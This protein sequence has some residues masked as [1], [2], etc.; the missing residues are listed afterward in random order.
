M[1][2]SA[3]RYIMGV[4]INPITSKGE[5]FMKQHFKN[6]MISAAVVFAM[7]VGMTGVS[8]HAAQRENKDSN[9]FAGLSRYSEENDRSDVIPLKIED[10]TLYEYAADD[11]AWTVIELDGRA[12]QVFS[13]ENLCVLME[14]G[15]LFYDGLT[16]V[17]PDGENVP[18][19]SSYGM[20]IAGKV[21]EQNEAEPFLDVNFNLQYLYFRALLAS[22]ELLCEDMEG[23][24]RVSLPGEKPAALAGNFILTE[25]GNV[26]YLNGDAKKLYDGGDIVAV[27][28]CETAARGVGLKANG[29]AV[30][31]WLDVEAPDLSEWKNLAAVR[32]GFYFTVG[33]DLDGGVHYADS[34]A[35]AMESVSEVLR[36]WPDVTDLAICYE[37]IV[38]LKEDGS[39]VMLDVGEYQ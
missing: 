36:T 21:L 26:Y 38:G 23:L 33:L 13:G 35:K 12:A 1:I 17:L 27:S 29:E 28:A 7:L 14:D 11:G 25:E 9:Q 30:S 16:E 5:H 32:Q 3:D 15:S 37:T 10:G 31:W 4:I 20:M 6:A 18:L 39:C 22:G 24:T 34:N 19:M 8:L 2:S